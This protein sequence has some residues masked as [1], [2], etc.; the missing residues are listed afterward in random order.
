MDKG[1]EG[2]SRIN[3]HFSGWRRVGSKVPQELVL[4]PVSFSTF[5]EE[6]EKGMNS[7]IFRFVTDF[8]S[9]VLCRYEK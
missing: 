8:V 3:E 1:W 4:G 5:I 9:Q 6:L 7:E 2:K